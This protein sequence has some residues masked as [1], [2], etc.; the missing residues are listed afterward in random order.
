MRRTSRILG[1]EKHINDG[2]TISQKLG[3]EGALPA[4]NSGD[5][6]LGVLLDRVGGLLVVGAEGFDV[7]FALPFED[8]RVVAAG[9][10]PKECHVRDPIPA[11]HANL[12]GGAGVAQA[13][14]R[15]DRRLG[16]VPQNPLLL[17]GLR[18]TLMRKLLSRPLDRNRG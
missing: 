10:F 8:Q 2:V 17:G 5:L 9:S 3:G 4:S 16:Q 13:K 7:G 15:L 6:M 11:A 14:R 12:G 1:A 18:S